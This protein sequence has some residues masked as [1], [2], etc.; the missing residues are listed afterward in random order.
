MAGNVIR[1]HRLNTHKI[2]Y[3]TCTHTRA[4]MNNAAAADAAA[5]TDEFQ[6]NFI[7]RS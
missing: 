5:Y 7:H 3:I 1:L 6:E 2:D 4:K